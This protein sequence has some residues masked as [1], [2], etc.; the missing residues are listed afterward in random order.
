MRIPVSLLMLVGSAAVAAAPDV[1]G[2]RDPLNLERF[3]HAWIVKYERDD[4]LLP[5]EF[6]VSRVD[7]THRDVRAE[8]KVRTD[9]RL[10][11]VTYRIPEG[12]PRQDVIDHYVSVLGSEL[13]FSCE[14]RYCGRSNHWANYIFKQAI[15]FGP[16]KNQ[17]YIAVNHAAH[18]VAVYVVERG[19]KRVYAHVLVLKPDKPVAV[20]ENQIL[21][22]RLAGEGYAVVEGVVP[23]HDGD[24]PGS[25]GQILGG[26][27][28]QL[29]IFTGHRIY[30]VCH[31][32]GS[33]SADVLITA[34]GRCSQ[35]AVQLLERDNG[36]ELV[37]F[38]AGPLLPRASGSA[39]R[40]ELILPHRLQHQ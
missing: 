16:D 14:G 11:A 28:D 24:L 32:Y 8:R 21:T 13:L 7:K 17:F 35:T 30:V 37:A 20:A 9:A 29:N 12:I 10:E 23:L 36:P 38:A 25:A 39:P 2:S 4:E 15:L 31:I 40:I 3:P 34:A 6:I 18:L 22:E 33:A 27:A 1:P 19:N 26:I 5:R